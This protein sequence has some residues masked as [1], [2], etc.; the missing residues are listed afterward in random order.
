MKSEVTG[1]DTSKLHRWQA[2]KRQF[3]SKVCWTWA[4]LGGL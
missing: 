4:F 2:P 1:W 3:C